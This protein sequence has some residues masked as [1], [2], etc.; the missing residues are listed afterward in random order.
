MAKRRNL[1]PSPEQFLLIHEI[2]KL[3]KRSRASIYRW[4]KAGTFPAPYKIGNGSIGWKRS[5][6]DAWAEQL[7]EVNY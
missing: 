1:N 5:D 3:T 7:Q 6:Y 4:C 2:I